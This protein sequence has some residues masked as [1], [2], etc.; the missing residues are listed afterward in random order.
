[1]KEGFAA[2]EAMRT[3][4]QNNNNKESEVMPPYIQENYNVTPFENKLSG[5]VKF[6]TARAI[7]SLIDVVNVKKCLPK[8]LLVIMDKDLVNDLDVFDPDAS[9]STSDLVQWFV[10]AN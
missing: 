3:E 4:S 9:E 2:F 8:Y 1:M 10:R 7:N 5:G 6:A